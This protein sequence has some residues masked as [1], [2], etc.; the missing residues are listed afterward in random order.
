M[1]TGTSKVNDPMKANPTARRTVEDTPLDFSV[2][3]L[4]P[5]G[6]TR[7]RQEYNNIGDN[8]GEM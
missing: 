8:T 2:D 6:T 7:K 1:N 4:I 5:S 3:H